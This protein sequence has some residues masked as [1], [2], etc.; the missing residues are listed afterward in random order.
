MLNE[1][2]TSI[3]DHR[4]TG[5]C[6]Y[7][8]ADLLTNALL[9]YI[10]GGE[11]YA[12]MSEFAASRARA[13][14]LFVDVETS[15]SQ[16]TFERLMKVVNPDEIERCLNDYGKKFIESLA[17][18]Q[19]VIDGKKLRGTAPTQRGEKGDFL[20]NAFVSD[21]Q[22]FLGQTPLTDKENE[23]AAIPRLLSKL[24]VEGA[25][26]SIDA[27]GTQ[28]SIAQNILDKGAHYLLAVKENQGSLYEAITTAFKYHKPLDCAEQMDSDHGRVETR[29]CRI[30]DVTSI[31]CPD[32]RKAISR[33][34][35]LKTL[36]EI[37]STV[38]HPNRTS[39]AKR[40]YISDEDYPKAAYFNMLVRGHWAIENNLHWALDV[41]FKEDACRSRKNNAAQNLS[42][43][44][45][46]ALDIVKRYPDKRSIRKR[47]FKS[48]IDNEYML[49]MLSKIKF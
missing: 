22:L 31:D 48:A 28:V 21:N 43:C 20:L 45:K 11:D 7:L 38:V 1:I 9:T 32:D 16:D 5:R 8:L 4:V 19:V 3:Q 36:V 39:H 46:L 25:T 42:L 34:P 15:P 47:L 23:I 6:T 24:D 27:M 26:V 30:L 35:M 13:F 12:D 2:F 14:G 17:E 40:Y 41:I 37:E 18:K 29:V 49:S 44:R 10:A 33:W